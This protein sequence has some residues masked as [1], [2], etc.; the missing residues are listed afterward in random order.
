[1][2]ADGTYQLTLNTPNGQMPATLELATSGPSLSGRMSVMGRVVE[3]NDGTVEGSD[4]SW[5]L[6]V[7]DP[8]AIKVRC[9]AT[10]DGDSITGQAEMGPF[11]AAS[12]TG[13]RA[14]AGAERPDDEVADVR[15]LRFQLAFGSQFKGPVRTALL[16]GRVGMAPGDLVDTLLDSQRH[17][18]LVG[19]PVSVNNVVGARVR[20]GPDEGDGYLME[21]IDNSHVSFALH[22]PAYPEGHYSTVTLM[23]KADK[24]GGSNLTIYQQ[25]VPEELV[26]DVRNAWERDY[27]K[28]LQRTEP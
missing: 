22:P 11:G 10:V 19:Y 3:F 6:E 2:R 9:T 20:L 5:S 27:L 13:A 21:Y 25:N 14:T 8:V 4:L 26:P 7:T 17:S 28:V 18:A 24:A 15:L 1:M 23:V 16:T 12:F